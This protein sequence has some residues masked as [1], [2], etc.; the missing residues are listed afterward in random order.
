M[1]LHQML[2]ACRIFDVLTAEN[3]DAAIRSLD[4]RGAVDVAICDVRGL[5][6]IRH[7]ASTGQASAL[8]ILGSVERHVL[9]NAV[10]LARQLGL[11]V[12]GALHKPASPATL[13][14]LLE[15]YCPAEP[16]PG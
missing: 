1:A 14:R 7:L 13:H 3:V 5:D 12:L 15:D 10:Q 16:V 4:R 8:I 11:R 6:M 2:N 9:D